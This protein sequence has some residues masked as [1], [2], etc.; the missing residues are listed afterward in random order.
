MVLLYWLSFWIH[1]HYAINKI[2]HILVHIFLTVYPPVMSNQQGCPGMMGSQI[3]PQTQQGIVGPYPSVSS[4]QVLIQKNKQLQEMSFWIIKMYMCFFSCKKVP[5]Q[6]QQ[7]SYPAML[8]SG[9]G[10]QTQCLVPPSGVQVYC[11]SMAPS[12]PPPLNMMGVSFQSN[13][14][15]NGCSV[16]Q[17]QCWY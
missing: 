6:Q 12:S 10:G 1:C 2:S 11:S 4:Y 14:C 9:Q 7:Q 16:N 8:V 17:N 3:L 5:Q 13:S 15:K